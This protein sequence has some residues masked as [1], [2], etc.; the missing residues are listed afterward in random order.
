M[1]AM[2]AASETTQGVTLAWAVLGQNQTTGK[3]EVVQI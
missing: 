2:K 1:S 3:S